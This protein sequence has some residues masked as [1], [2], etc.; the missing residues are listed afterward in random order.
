MVNGTTNGIG[1][2]CPDEE[3]FLMPTDIQRVFDKIDELRISVTAQIGVATADIARVEGYQRAQSDTLSVLK[4][5]IGD[6]QQTKLQAATTAVQVSNIERDLRDMKQ[7]AEKAD[8]WLRAENLVKYALG[9]IGGSGL[10]LLFRAH[11][12]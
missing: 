10:A 5:A 7:K 3:P 8:N 9:A 11:G 4:E 2:H 1:S 12:G 6:V